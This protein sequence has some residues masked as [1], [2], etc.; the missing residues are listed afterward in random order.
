MGANALSPNF[1]LRTKG[2][3]KQQITALA[4]PSLTIVR[5]SR[6]DAEHE[7]TRTGE[8]LGLLAAHVFKPLITKLYLPVTAGKIAAALLDGVISGKPGVKMVESDAL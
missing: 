8:K 1:Y 5:T 6:I 3:I 4:Y 2:K 7:T